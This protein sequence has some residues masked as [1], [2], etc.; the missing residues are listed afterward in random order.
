[1]QAAADALTGAAAK[2]MQIALGDPAGAKLGGFETLPDY[3]RGRSWGR[4]KTGFPSTLDLQLEALRSEFLCAARITTNAT[5]VD[6]TITWGVGV[7]SVTKN[8]PSDYIEVTLTEDYRENTFAAWAY[9]PSVITIPRIVQPYTTKTFRL[10][11][12]TAP[13]TG[14]AADINNRAVVFFTLG[15]APVV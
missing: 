8:E 12:F 3:E 2:A 5:T 4:D 1:M 15:R 7:E 9:I 6:P 13:F 14:P 11:F 10:E